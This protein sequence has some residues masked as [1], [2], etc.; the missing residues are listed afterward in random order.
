MRADAP[1]R[2]RAEHLGP[3]RRR[4]QVLDT[5][6]EIIAERGVAAVT[7]GEIAARLGVT[8]PVVYAC[9]PGRGEVLGAL[10]ERES[11]LVLSAVL[12]TLPPPRTGTVEQLFVDGFHGFLDA[13]AARPVSWRLIL[14]LDTDP[15]LVEA[16]A[17]G[18]A[19]ILKQVAAVMRP[20]LQRWDVPDLDAAL[21]VL[22]EVF[23]GIGESGARLLLDPS[24]R[25]TPGP[26]A[27]I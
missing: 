12:G 14:G 23:A 22:T 21:P 9:Y 7:M 24:G 17:H 6:L 16:V 26:L 20:L 10:L 3:D 2:S 4:P 13:V 25:W 27:E 15:V 11:G 18:R 19:L 1:E 5:A 8:R